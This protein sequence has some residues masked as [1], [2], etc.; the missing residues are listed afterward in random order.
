M[1]ATEAYVNDTPGFRIPPPD[2][3]E[4]LQAWFAA[5]RERGVREPGAVALAT[6]Q[7]DGRTS[8]R[9]V[10]ISALT[11]RGF[12]FTSHAG[13]RKGRELA[14]LPWASGVLYWRETGQQ[15]VL[16]GPVERLPDSEADELWYARPVHTHAMSVVSDQSQPI[17]DEGEL[18]AEAARLSELGVLPR[19]EPF[20]AYLLA[21]DT[22]E[23][24]QA[25][26]DR[27]HHRLAYLRSG[28]GWST[29]HLQP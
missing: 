29:R 22:V 17:E 20:A 14:A 24:W 12:V 3:I 6:A 8:S 1:S 28:D 13:S 23:F 16:A 21:P 4:L 10:Q 5:A 19:P 25:A 26:E 2:P 15:I 18:R 9:T 27:L 7:T 11:D